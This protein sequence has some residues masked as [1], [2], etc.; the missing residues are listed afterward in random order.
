[1]SVTPGESDSFA[2]SPLA[3]A[4]IE[5]AQ[6]IR[7]ATDVCSSSITI[8][9]KYVPFDPDDD[10][11]CDDDEDSASCSQTW[12][13]VESAGLT[14]GDEG[15]GGNTCAGEMSL[16]LEVGIYRCIEIPERG[17][18]PSATD[19]FVAAMQAMEDMQALYCAASSCDV[20]SSFSVGM[21]TPLGP[22]GGQYGGSWLFEVT[23]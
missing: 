5:F 11:E 23:L 22:S 17:E 9:S 7:Q 3:L 21:W 18:A 6:C 1:M 19:V 10:D 15:W 8:G 2:S 4:L 14:P 13:R 16:V 20:W 12:V